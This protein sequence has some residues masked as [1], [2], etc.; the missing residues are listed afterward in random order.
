M[1]RLLSISTLIMME[2]VILG[3]KDPKTDGLQLLN[4]DAKSN[5]PTSLV[6]RPSQ[7]PRTTETVI[8]TWDGSKTD[9]NTTVVRGSPSHQNEKSN[10]PGVSHVTSTETTSY[11]TVTTVCYPGAGCDGAIE[12]PP[13]ATTCVGSE[14]PTFIFNYTKPSGAN[15]KKAYTS[16]HVSVQVVQNLLT[17][18]I[19]E[20]GKYASS[21]FSIRHDLEKDQTLFSGY[22]RP[23]RYP[24][25]DEKT[26][27]PNPDEDRQSF[28]YNEPG[29]ETSKTPS[30]DARFKGWFIQISC[31]T[32]AGFFNGELFVPDNLIFP[33]S[34]AFLKD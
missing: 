18:S 11:G 4:T 16:P 13:K 1:G 21:Q 34:R 3:C 8:T 15:E 20:G 10:D 32:G 14:C 6:D 7:D 27:V 31:D 23:F 30:S 9:Y 24:S 12:H 5:N 33:A 26:S 17:A 22:I 25:Y 29:C 19:Y 28:V 2:L